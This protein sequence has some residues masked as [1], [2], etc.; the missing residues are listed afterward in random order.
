MIENKKCPFC[1]ADIV[2]SYERPSFSFRIEDGEIVRDD[3]W[4]GTGYDDP[5]FSFHCSNDKEHDIHLD[6]LGNWMDSIEFAFHNHF[7]NIEQIKGNI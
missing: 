4:T 2:F 1:N 3:A 6:E 5:F 7:S